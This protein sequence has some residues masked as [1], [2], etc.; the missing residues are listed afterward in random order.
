MC[1]KGLALVLAL[2][3]IACLTGGLSASAA[4]TCP[5]MPKGATN[6]FKPDSMKLLGDGLLA[7]YENDTFL[8]DARQQDPDV[9]K[10]VASFDFNAKMKKD[11]AI[12]FWAR[13]PNATDQYILRIMDDGDGAYCEVEVSANEARV[14]SS[15]G[16]IDRYTLPSTGKCLASKTESLLGEWK[17]VTICVQPN[18]GTTDISLFIDGEAMKGNGRNTS[19]V[20]TSD[21]T[22]M[23]GT[24]A[25][26]MMR[27]IRVFEVNP[28]ATAFEPPF[29]PDAA[30]TGDAADG[31]D[32]DS[33]GTGAALIPST[34]APSPAG[35]SGQ[36][37]AG[38]ATADWGL[39]L[40]I[41]GG[42]I[43]LIGGVAVLLLLLNKKK[44]AA[45]PSADTEKEGDD[46]ENA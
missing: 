28:K 37:G 16:T 44:A 15:T 35:S 11:Y 38:E 7:F 9:G 1:K 21:R 10:M 8:A 6:L 45:S 18:G 43:V 46:H 24:T 42:A 31:V 19:S 40:G 29:D 26:L 32:G 14:F 30:F 12:S 4:T 33:G 13:I 27:G 22:L 20:D 3:L 23:F 39:I 2:V 36:S 34:T 25:P 17:H 41:A 5:Q